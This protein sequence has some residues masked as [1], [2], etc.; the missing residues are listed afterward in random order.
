MRAGG[1]LA[2]CQVV[3]AKSRLGELG[4]STVRRPMAPLP[5][6]WIQTNEHPRRPRRELLGSSIFWVSR[7]SPNAQCRRW[8]LRRR[9]APQPLRQLTR[10][11]YRMLRRVRDPPRIPQL[12]QVGGEES[13]TRRIPVHAGV[14]SPLQTRTRAA[15]RARSACARRPGRHARRESRRR[16]DRW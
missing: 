7:M 14:I 16:P 9:D 2:A 11:G 12:T 6:E 15:H 3:E 5:D 1:A 13:L 10:G 4:F 8:A